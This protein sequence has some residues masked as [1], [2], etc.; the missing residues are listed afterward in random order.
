MSNDSENCLYW[1]VVIGFR[2]KYLLAVW[3]VTPV[4]LLVL[5][6]YLSGVNLAS[7]IGRFFKDKGPQAA[8][9]LYA[10]SIM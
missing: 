10:R 9:S 6:L 1:F 5:C 3:E 2:G 8:A 7:L 4:V